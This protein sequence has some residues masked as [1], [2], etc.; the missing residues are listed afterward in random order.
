MSKKLFVFGDSVVHGIWDDEMG[1]WVNRLDVYLKQNFLSDNNF[2]EVYNLGVDGDT[3]E[4]L[5]NRFEFETYQ[6]TIPEQC[7]IFLIAIGV[8]DSAFLKNQDENFIPRIQ[9]KEN[10]QYII[11]LAKKYSER[12]VFIG[13]TPV[14]E[15]ITNSK[16]GVVCYKNEYIEEYDKIIKSVCEKNDLIFIDVLN[17]FK[18]GNH[19][20]LL[21]GDGL[22][23]NSNGHQKIFEIIKNSLLKNK[24]I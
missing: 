1:G 4:N 18:K 2:I 13:L 24:I 12:I 14:D 10:L 7:D 17:E 23:P 3:S 16:E 20:K 15:K 22:H 9:F 5:L 19:K 6:R 11:T 8:N 21:D